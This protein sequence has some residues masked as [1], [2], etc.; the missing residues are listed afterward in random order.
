[1]I[2]IQS[3]HEKDVIPL[4]M[5]I[6]E[7]NDMNGG[8]L[9]FKLFAKNHIKQKIGL[10]TLTLLNNIILREWKNSYKYDIKKNIAGEI[11]PCATIIKIAPFILKFENLIKPTIIIL[12]WTI[13]E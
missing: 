9:M 12:M 13:D 8:N 10:I 3:G 1:M 5:Q 4:I 11:N 7:K 2:I 6:S